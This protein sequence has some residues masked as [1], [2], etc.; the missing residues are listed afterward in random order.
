MSK[1]NLRNRKNELS[2]YKLRQ[3]SQH[4]NFNF[5]VLVYLFFRRNIF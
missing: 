3:K 1:I 5:F 2:Q 4:L